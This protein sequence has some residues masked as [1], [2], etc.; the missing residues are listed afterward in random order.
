MIYNAKPGQTLAEI[1]DEIYLENPDYLRDFHNENSPLTEYI[2]GDIVHAT[3]LSVPSPK[4]I[5]EINLRIKENHESFYDFPADGQFP[6]AFDLW[7]G[8]YQ[9]TRTVYFNEEILNNYEQKVQLTFEFIKDN[10]LYFRFS[11]FDFKKNDEISD[12]KVSTLAKM[13]MEIIYPVR[14]VISSNGKI[15]N[16][17]PTKDHTDI[18][19]ELDSVKNFFPDQYS[20]A[21]IEKMKNIVKDPKAFLEKF[22]NTLLN[23]FMF[24]AFYRTKLGNWTSSDVYSD[25][26]PWLFDAQPVRFEFRN[27]LLPKESLD[28]E[29]IK[30]LQKGTSSDNRNQ[31]ALHSED[32]QY[33]NTEITYK[34]IDCEHFAE[35][36]FNRKKNSLQRIEA[37]FRNYVQENIEKEIFL[38]EKMKDNN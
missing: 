11:A 35:Y 38:L 13:C 32:S 28:D 24:G 5:K 3:R 33:R 26:Y 19:A 8:E 1:C 2:E 36:I 16:I 34:S 7:D 29:W 6:F 14:L 37:I 12:H 27:T 23:T 17:E 10:D 9:I 22:K 30:I 21:Y 18:S 4:Q 20:S 15:Q 25:F 31:E